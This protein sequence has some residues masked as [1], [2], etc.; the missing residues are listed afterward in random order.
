M[1]SPGDVLDNRYE[2]LAP[3]AEGGMGAVYRARRMLLGDEVALKIVR[4][5]LTANFAGER[6]VRESRIAARLRHPAIVAIYDFDM[7]PDS[8][9]YLVM[10]LLSGPSLRDEIKARGRMDPADVRLIMPS[11]CSALHLAHTNDVVH[12]DIKP[13]NIVAHDYPGGTRVYK[14]VDFGVANLRETNDDTRLTSAHQFVGTVTYASPEQLTAGGVD[15]RSD[16]YSLCIVMF[17]MITGRVPF[18]GTDTL[19]IVTAHL[20]RTAPR[21][22][23]VR[24]EVPPWL[25][26]AVARGLAKTPAERWQTMAELGAALAAGDVAA[27]GPSTRPA[28]SSGLA[29]TYEIGESLGRGRLGSEVFR[30]SHRALGS[31]VTIRILRSDA[32]NW[33]AARERFLHEAK[34]LQVAHPSIIQ[35]RDYGEEADFVY[36][37]T[38]FIEGR[39]LR[40]LLRAEGALPWP[41]LRP[42]LTQLVEA[43]RV[44][45]RRKILLC[46]LSPEIIRVREPEAADAEAVEEGER[47]MISTGGIGRAQDLLATLNDRTLRGIALDDIELR[48]IAPEL[49]TGATVD[50]RSDVFT[51]G[52]LAYEM[53]TGRPPYDGSSMQDLLG[54]MLAGTPADPRVS[55]PELPEQVSAAVLKALSPAPADRF[56]TVAELAKQLIPRTQQQRFDRDA[57]RVS[58]SP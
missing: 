32:A 43:A 56:A 35:V 9:P 24:P 8:A 54:H 20:T 14:I 57:A 4:P 17:E 41:R 5:D 21:L 28:S 13:A 2:I 15:A 11:I 16:I 51:I 25:D 39:S 26:D 45:H 58:G 47:L 50:V 38:E 44:L 53:A 31:P 1:L 18:E 30:G 6:F 3:L 36:V 52:T 42:L 10:E 29:A 23:S 27:A 48:Y 19:E 34:S 49:L 33:P 22:R 40:H 46:G 7:P 37:V 55:H 12:R